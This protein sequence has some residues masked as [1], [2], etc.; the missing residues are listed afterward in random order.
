MELLLTILL[1]M[2][3]CAIIFSTCTI[4][5]NYYVR[6]FCFY[7]V[8]MAYKYELRRLH[9]TGEIKRREDSAFEWFSNKYTYEQFLYSFKPLKLEKWFTEEEI[10]EINR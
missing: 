1:C 8:D 10:K 7:L 9:E 4:I 6:N 5:R 3:V 2:C